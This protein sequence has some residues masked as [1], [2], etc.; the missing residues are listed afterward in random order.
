[1]TNNIIE[2]ISIIISIVLLYGC[3]DSLKNEDA[4]EIF[5]YPSGATASQYHMTSGGKKKGEYSLYFE[6][7]KLKEK[8]IWKDD[9]TQIN[10]QILYYPSGVINEYHFY[11]I[12]GERRFSR[13]FDT[14][15]KLIEEK[16][17]FLAYVEIKG[18]EIFIGDTQIVKIFVA[19]PPECYF[20][21]YGIKNNK[22]YK[23]FKKTK[24]PYMIIWNSIMK[25]TGNY[26]IPYE[27]E[28]HDR[29]NNTREIRKDNIN[30]K[31]S[32][33]RPHAPTHL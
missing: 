16:G 24:Y 9:T 19:T 14:L 25:K 7:G 6:N 10:E 31:V 30:Y 27:V 26:I 8:G 28:F 12:I 33:V 23:A 18:S 29:I 3:N 32:P 21:I 17:D 4:I 13:F 1:M 15:G 20:E 11:N 22:R 5:Y 2:K